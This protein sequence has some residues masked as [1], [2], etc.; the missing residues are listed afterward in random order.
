MKIINIILCSVLLGFN[1]QFAFS[2]DEKDTTK[3][4][5]KFTVVKE[6]PKTCVKDQYRSG[7]C[8]SF[9]S[10]SFMESELL[11]MG[12]GEFDLS[13]MFIVRKTYEEKARLFVRMHG[14]SNF[15]AGG[16][17]NDIL[18][19]IKNYGLVPDETYN[20]LV[21]GEDKHIHGEMDGVL[22]AIVKDVIKNE[23]KKL[24]PNWGMAYNSVLDAYLGAEP[25]NFKYK[26]A[27]YTPKTFTD[28]VLGLKADDYVLFSS[29][30]HHPFYENF[31]IEIPDN[32]TM[33]E[34]FNVKVDELSTII[35][36]AIN[37]GY[38]VGWAGDVSED[39]FTWRKGLAIVPEKDVENMSDLE[40]GKWEALSEKE[41]NEALYTFE[42]PMKEKVITQEIRQRAFDDYSTTDDHGMHI[43][44]IAKDQN[45][46]K[47]YIVKN[48]WN[49]TQNPYGGYLYMSEAFMKYKTMSIMIHKNAIPKEIAEKMK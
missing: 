3:E 45:G 46:N 43:T 26:G 18:H 29:F 9:A 23:N 1:A 7:T 47:Y 11:R 35:D 32:W 36:N 24:T 25:K 48:S 21:I 30:N 20:G 6:I 15:G 22:S 34:V 27:E 37:N 49:T 41:K 17:L 4:G 19:V 40:R 2:Q 14:M 10:A 12:K 8:W 5:F 31:I 44:G 16:E 13:E 42:K 39:G 28:K 38:T 33:G